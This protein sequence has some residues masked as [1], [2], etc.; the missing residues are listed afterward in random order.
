MPG[1]S[2]AAPLRAEEGGK[3]PAEDSGTQAARSAPAAPL[4]PKT[5]GA[6][7]GDPGPRRAGSD[8]LPRPCCGRPARLR[9]PGP[10]GPRC[11][12]PGPGGRP[13]APPKRPRA[14]PLLRAWQWRRPRRPPR[15]ALTGC[16]TSCDRAGPSRRSPLCPGHRGG[17]P[18]GRTDGSG[19]GARRL[20]RRR[21]RGGGARR[22]PPPRPSL[23]APLPRPL[24][25]RGAG[26]GG[27]AA[28]RRRP[29]CY[30]CGRMEERAAR[31]PT[32]NCH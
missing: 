16:A 6:P 9:L 26:G 27:A 7:Q 22:P 21:G 28:G 20:W 23:P 5:G 12:R 10:R 1:D 2:E 13:H 4:G 25:H 19:R 24:A 17:R 3:G 14:A 15:S 29:P 18:P 30:R 11:S 31:R 8:L 32:A